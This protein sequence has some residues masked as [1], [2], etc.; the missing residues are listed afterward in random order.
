MAAA[1]DRNSR[2]TAPRSSAKD[3]KDAKKRPQTASKATSPA[4][5]LQTYRSKRDFAVTREPS[6]NEAASSTAN[7][8]IQA[9]SFCV[10]KHDATRLHYDF[11]IEW[12]GVLKSWA[13]TRGP[14]LDPADKRLA[15]RTEDH[16]LAY[17]QFEGTIPKKQ[18]GG[19]TVMLW[20][21]GHWEP[22]EDPD[23][24]FEKG[25]LKMRLFGKKMK[26]DWALVRMKPKSGEKRENWLMIKEKDDAVDR[27]RNLLTADR[28]VKTDRTMSAIAKA[29]ETL[30]DAALKGAPRARKAAEKISR[31]ATEAARER[32]A[33]NAGPDGADS[34]ADT[35]APPKRGPSSEAARLSGGKLPAFV[36]PQ[37]ATLVDEAPDGGGWLSEMKYDG[38]RVLIAVGGGEAKLFTRSG[39]D[40]TEKFTGIAAGALSLDCD[41][42][43][44]DGEVVAFDDTGRT[45]FSTLQAALKSGGPLAC[46]CFDLLSLDGTD[47]RTRPL[48]ERKVALHDLLGDGESGSS[49]ALLYSEHVEGNGAAVLKSLC[50]KG[51]EGIVAKRADAPYRS[52][53]S[54]AWLKVK[55]SRRQEF[56]VG[57]WS[58][59]NKAGRP[60]SSILVGVF[61]GEDLVYRGRVGSGFTEA[62]LDGLHE[63]FEGLA[64]KTSPF[65]GLPADIA[66]G[67]KFVAPQLVA[68]IEFAELTADGHIRH[69]VFKGLREDKRAKAVTG[70]TPEPLEATGTD[71]TAK[72]GRT[73]GQPKTEA[74]SREPTASRSPSKARA[75][76]KIAGVRI[77]HPDRVVFTE[78]QVTKGELAHYYETI[79]ERLLIYGGD[80]PLSLV[81]CP[82]GPTKHCFLQKHASR[83]FPSAVNAVTIQEKDGGTAQY[84]SIDS[85][86]GLVAAVQMNALEFHIW[87]ARNDA[88]EKPDRLV[89]DLDPDESLSFG[90]VRDA[91]FDLR[92][93]LANVGLRT[94]VL[95]TGG[96]GVHIVAPLERRQGWD[97]MKAFARGFA[98]AQAEAEPKRFV[99][100]MSKARRKG[101]IF[102]DWLRNE[103]G[104]TAIAPYS[105]RS[106][107]GAPVATPVSWDELKSLDAANGF[108]PE[109]VIERLSESDPWG[110][111][112]STRQSITKAMMRKL[113]RKAD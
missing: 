28:S 76:T 80:R 58:P 90:N 85:A 69:G 101:R 86:A 60:F 41:G 20:D 71:A 19:G 16:P 104:S 2:K 95:V 35:D 87:G 82:E 105:T 64:R 66:K 113:D 42:A 40:W 63:N 12:D 56:V 25:S 22:R 59:S 92:D 49:S 36:D 68:E 32:L 99:A 18:Y 53:R 100:T 9:L 62:T 96:K 106:R 5:L 21:R 52:G 54:K 30:D 65:S 79:A 43:L 39:K 81:R 45:D 44:I 57:G 46:F 109:T 26:G 97:D 34:D 3:T 15:V 78:H 47:L 23:A 108:R 7:A 103:R 29:D 55:C 72:A 48:V 70:E 51:H 24:G 17:G 107:A 74:G 83:G 84:L 31:D 91:A 112:S 67:A 13:V 88:L 8:S 98:N 4:D 93:R 61:D 94:F 110:Q 10:Q 1:N 89:F 77:S 33:G 111:Y 38:Y 6:G 11:R 73:K 27:R 75:A 50:A 14:S 37:L 102:I